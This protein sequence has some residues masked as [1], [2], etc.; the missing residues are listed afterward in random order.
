MYEAE[1]AFLSPEYQAK[2]LRNKNDVAFHNPISEHNTLCPHCE[3]WYWITL[4]PHTI[5]DITIEKSPSFSNQNKLIGDASNYLTCC[6]KTSKYQLVWPRPSLKSWP[7]SSQWGRSQ[8]QTAPTR[9]T[10][11]TCSMSSCRLSTTH[12]GHCWWIGLASSGKVDRQIISQNL[13]R[14]RQKK[15]GYFLSHI[16]W[17]DQVGYI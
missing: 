9:T 3:L 6:C 17:K 13:L 4:K 12:I 8:H 2:F 15:I 11:I 5:H 10:S 16:A 14:E 1:G 7:P